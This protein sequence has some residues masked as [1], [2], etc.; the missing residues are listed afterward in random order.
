METIVIEKLTMQY[1]KNK[2]LDSV[3]MKIEP[4]I[5]GLVGPNG[6][7]KTTL[8]RILATV[9]T[10]KSGSIKSGE[11]SW[12]KS[13][14]VRRH[15]GYLSQNF[16]MYPYISVNEALNHAAVIKGLQKNQISAEI[17]R[18]LDITNLKE[19]R[20]K[21]VKNL[22][23]GM[24][25]RLG[26]AQAFLGSPELIILDEPTAGLDPEERVRFREMIEKLDK[27]STVLI[28]TH[29]IS[30]VEA[31]C[32][33]VAFLNSGKL[34]K[35]GN[36]SDILPQGSDKTLEDYYMELVKDVKGK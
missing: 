4:G 25:R 34:I 3:S 10:P 30:D 24:V 13:N 2:A 11:L 19:Q 33:H 32:E 21:K 8:I 36:I 28:S 23:G 31:C 14:E 20:D 17:D 6:A 15:L 18:V 27:G 7:G 29:I 1:G 16:G 9:M 35:S 26:I 12:S 5:F 22:S